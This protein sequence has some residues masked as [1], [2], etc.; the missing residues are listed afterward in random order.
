MSL[1]RGSGIVLSSTGFGEADVIS[2][3]LTR[4][5]GKISIVFKGIRKSRSRPRSSTEPGSF[6]SLDFYR[7]QGAESGTAREISLKKFHS[8]LRENYRLI[9]ILSFMLEVAE[10]TTG[11]D[12]PDEELFSLLASGIIA[13]EETDSPLHLLVFYLLHFLRLQ[14]I[15]PSLEKCRSCGSSDFQQFTLDLEGLEILCRDCSQAHEHLLHR[16][17]ID[18]ITRCLSCKFTDIDVKPWPEVDISHLAYYFTLFLEHY[19][20][21]SLRSKTL[22]FQALRDSS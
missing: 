10:R 6:I 17:H 4:E 3:V 14:G 13:L 22:L 15:L 7:R 19:F 8:R 11:F 21:I 18:F 9:I 1:L 16:D 20:S 12:T 5:H 2:R